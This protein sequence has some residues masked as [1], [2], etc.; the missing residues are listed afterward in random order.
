MSEHDSKKIKTLPR[1]F[2]S[3]KNIIDVYVIVDTG[4]TDGTQEYITDY[5]REIKMPGQL[6]KKPWVDFEANHQIALDLEKKK[7]I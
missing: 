2:E 4:S 5:M 3:L 6:H 7:S 1:L